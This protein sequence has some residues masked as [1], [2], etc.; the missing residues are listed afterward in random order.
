M[1]KIIDALRRLFDPSILSPLLVAIGLLVLCGIFN[2]LY[3][4]FHSPREFIA[5]ISRIGAIPSN[6]LQSLTE[7]IMALTGYSMINMEYFI[8]PL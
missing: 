6:N 3:V 2:I 1:V 7:L 4:M 8:T 5:V